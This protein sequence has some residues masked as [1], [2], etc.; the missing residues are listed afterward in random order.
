MCVC[1]WRVEGKREREN[2][3]K[4]GSDISSNEEHGGWC[5]GGHHDITICKSTTALLLPQIQSERR[6]G[7]CSTF[8]TTSQSQ[9]RTSA[10]CTNASS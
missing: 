4:V 8:Q 3:S 1:G 9:P 5:Q 10:S 6:S 7:W 2:K